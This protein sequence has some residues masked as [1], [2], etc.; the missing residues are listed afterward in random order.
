MRLNILEVLHLYRFII[1][2]IK[3]YNLKTVK[4]SIKIDFITA[5]VKF[6]K[7]ENISIKTVFYKSFAFLN[8]N[9]LCTDLIFQTIKASPI[10]L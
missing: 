4:N 7:S 5:L 9:L 6:L 10:K 3:S 1:K 2:F 8:F